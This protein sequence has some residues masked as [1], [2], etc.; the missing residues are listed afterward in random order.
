MV[1]VL[2]WN[3][4]PHV[5]TGYGWDH[6]AKCCPANSFPNRIEVGWSTPARKSCRRIAFYDQLHSVWRC[7]KTFDDPWNVFGVVSVIL[8]TM[9]P[10]LESRIL[11]LAAVAGLVSVWLKK[12]N[13]A[14]RIIVPRHREVFYL[15][16]WGRQTYKTP[17]HNTLYICS[18]NTETIL[19]PKCN[20]CNYLWISWFLSVFV[21][22]YKGILRSENRCAAH[23]RWIV[24]RK[25]G[26]TIV[27]YI[28]DTR[29]A[30][31]RACSR[32]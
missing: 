17:V 18:A 30:D 29:D 28:P 13:V 22:T 20:V 2:H 3:I 1:R 9:L 4:F 23:M 19:T 10:M 11:L 25:T 31:A 24:D 27:R 8:D 15:R 7:H 21:C 12:K 5:C 32:L 6:E 14:K 16:I 26:Q